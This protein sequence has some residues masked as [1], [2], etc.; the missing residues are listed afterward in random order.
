MRRSSLR[1]T[2]PSKLDPSGML[3][4]AKGKRHSVSWGNANTFQFKAMKAMFNEP[5]Q[6]KEQNEESEK[7]IVESNP[8]TAKKE[9]KVTEKKD[10]KEELDKSNTGEQN[11]TNINTNTTT[12]KEIIAGNDSPKNKKNEKEGKEK[13]KKK[14]NKKIENEKISTSISNF[15]NN[16]NKEEEQEKNQ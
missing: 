16:E 14:S 13:I 3:N 4:K 1:Y 2:D 10:Q 15:S 5:G 7:K 9:E 12:N 8:N 6:I 11:L